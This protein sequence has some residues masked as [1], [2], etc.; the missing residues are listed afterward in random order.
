MA[1][2]PIETKITED[3]VRAREDTEDGILSVGGLAHRAGMLGSSAS[4]EPGRL[5]LAKFVELAR[6]ERNL[7]PQG[8]AVHAGV[9]L[10][11]VVALE[12]PEW[13]SPSAQVIES[14]ARSL[15]VDPLPLLELGGFNRSGGVELGDVAVQ[16]AARLEP[17]NPLEPQE[18]EALSWLR[19]HVFKFRSQHA[20]IG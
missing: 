18:R 6:R 14:V 4:P 3:W 11:D 20:E 8:L 7:S 2:T 1:H 9:E 5:T 17:V 16:F 15:D 12:K 10:G 19:N 13:P